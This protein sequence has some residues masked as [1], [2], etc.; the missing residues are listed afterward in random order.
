M[1]TKSVLKRILKLLLGYKKELILTLIFN[2][3]ISII[4]LVDSLLL[5]Y[6]IDNVLYSNAK[7]TLTTI[8]IVMLL[9]AFLQT[10]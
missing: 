3:L 4:E 1:I 6:L 9:V 2:L 10:S 5:S 7:R 8:A